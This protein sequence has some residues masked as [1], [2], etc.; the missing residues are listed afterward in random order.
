MRILTIIY[1][2][3]THHLAQVSRGAAPFDHFAA[4]NRYQGGIHVR[5]DRRLHQPLGII[6]A[7]T[8]AYTRIDTGATCTHT[9]F[10]SFMQRALGFILPPCLPTYSP[11][12][13]SNGWSTSQQYRHE[14][15][16]RFYAGCSCSG[17]TIVHSVLRVLWT[18][19][20]IQ[21]HKVNKT[22]KL[23]PS[24]GHVFVSIQV[25]V[26]FGM[27]WTTHVFVIRAG[28]HTVVLSE[29]D[30]S[31]NLTRRYK[32]LRTHITASTHC[33]HILKYPLSPIQTHLPVIMK[34]SCAN[35]YAERSAI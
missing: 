34:L 23:V 21:I 27:R 32:Q 12:P 25:M 8:S 3:L 11:I 15:Q 19:P 1:H 29:Y 14:Y 6:Q 5:V 30:A 4:F 17:N 22:N 7:C 35:M 26:L 10:H 2:H 28:H 13:C 20:Q 16:R 33:T 24:S 18:C 9:S 31:G